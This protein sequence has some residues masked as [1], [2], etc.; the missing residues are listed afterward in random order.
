[1]L[2]LAK[3]ERISERKRTKKQKINARISLKN[4]INRG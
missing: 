4:G 2:V 1:M 3:K